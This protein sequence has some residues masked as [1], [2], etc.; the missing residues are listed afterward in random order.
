M[1]LLADS[2]VTEVWFFVLAG[3]LRHS[4]QRAARAS[5]T[6]LVPRPSAAVSLTSLTASEVPS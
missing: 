3:V 5:E 1:Q 6:W 4:G 2:P